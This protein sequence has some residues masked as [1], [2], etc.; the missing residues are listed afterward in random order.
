MHLILSLGT[1]NDVDSSVGLP[2]VYSPH[3]TQLLIDK[4]IAELVQKRLDDAPDEHVQREYNSIR[5]QHLSE[6]SSHYRQ[7]RITES[8]KMIDKILAGKR[9]KV[10]LNGGDPNDVTEDTV[11]AELSSRFEIDPDNILIQIPTREPIDAAEDVSVKVV[12]VP[13]LDRLKYKIFCDLWERGKWI[14]S[15]DTFGG[16]FLVYPGDPLYFHASHIVHVV[17]AVDSVTKI[18]V[19]S[20]VTKG[21]MSVAV[22]KFCVIAYEDKDTKQIKYQ[23]VQ[24]QGK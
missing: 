1:E 23:T 15:G 13:S 5:A 2:A 9:K 14:T 18:T 6:F 22:N 24:W 19:N 20:L 10:A 3:Q 4:G 12:D 8:A 11:M 21:R 17:N 16:D 7:K